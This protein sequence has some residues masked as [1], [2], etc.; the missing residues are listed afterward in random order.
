MIRYP[1]SVDE[2]VDKI[3]AV[4]ATW[5]ARAFERTKLYTAARAYTGGTDFWGDI[6]TVYIELQHEKCVYCETKLQGAM[7]ASKVH[8]VEHFRPKSSV[9]YWPNDRFE[10]W[11]NFRPTWPVG[12]A[13]STGYYALAYHPLNYAISCTRC[14]STLKSNYFP[15][16]GQRD[17]HGHDPSGMRGEN[18]LLLYPISMIDTDDPQDLI[19]FDGVLAVSKQPDG[20]AYQRAATTI[21]FFQ[22]NHE[23]LVSGRKEMLLSLW[24]ALEKLKNP[25]SDKA[26]KLARVVVDRLCSPKEQFS[27]C[28]NSFRDLYSTDFDKAEEI[29]DKIVEASV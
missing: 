5:I 11:K 3:N 4:N 16:A 8:E 2:L 15:V 19:T 29:I 18:P 7:L 9:N 24:I 1:I 23:D 25:E 10:A 14:N 17:V 21:A 26:R 20:S 28:M 27:A 12:T 13:S 6:K 22:L